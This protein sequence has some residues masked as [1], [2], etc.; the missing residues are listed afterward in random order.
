MKKL[1]GMVLALALLMTVLFVGCGTKEEGAPSPDKTTDPT[2]AGAVGGGSL[3]LSVNP[4]IRLDYDENG[5]VTAV[6]AENADG[7]A[8]VAA[9]EELVGKEASAAVDI[10]VREIEAQGY[11]ISEIDD[12]KRLVML[13]FKTGSAVPSDGFVQGMTDH[14]R[15]TVA[16][17][18]ADNAV[19]TIGADDYDE[20]YADGGMPSVYI[21]MDKA[22]E[23][24]LSYAGVTD[25][26]ATFDDREFD[27][28]DGVAVY[29][30]EFV[31]GETEYDI[32]VDAVSGTVLKSKQK[33]VGHD[34][35][36]DD[37][38]P[39]GNYI[40]YEA[41]VTA[42]LAHVGVAEQDATFENERGLDREDGIV[43][44]E[45]EFVVGMTEYELE[46]NAETGEVVD[47]DREDDDDR[48]DDDDDDRDAPI[49][50]DASYIGA[51]RA[52]E[53]ALADAGVDASE[54]HFD[55]VELD[56]KKGVIV[57]DVEFDA[58]GVEY[59]YHIDAVSGEIL[60]AKQDTD[61]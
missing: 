37:A 3:R 19:V 21:T 24:A 45:L 47:D 34:D 58:A 23:I 2:V 28:D 40:T 59:D 32:D 29:E 14:V 9:V 4:E 41:A 10:L 25:T 57:Y 35:D 46:I 39:D 60:K 61:D 17:L 36:E 27:F 52:K 20:R 13:Q 8:V 11:F 43:V 51:E 50:E 31:V 26:Q 54:A 30:L 16:A 5:A 56:S 18:G 22:K 33:T 12:E 42:A 7:E 15:D 44:Y 1:T 6:V 48:G 49:A 53:L 38:I 55:Q